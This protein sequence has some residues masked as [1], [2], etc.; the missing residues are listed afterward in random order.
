MLAVVVFE[1]S[2]YQLISHGIVQLLVPT[3]LA[4]DDYCD[5]IIRIS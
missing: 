4:F 1:I 3:A 5:G 2:A